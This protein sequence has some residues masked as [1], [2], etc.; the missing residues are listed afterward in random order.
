MIETER[1]ILRKFL[2]SDA[3]DMLKNWISDN[4][5]Q[6]RYGE[7]VFTEKRDVLEL[8][9]KWESQYRFAIILK[10]TGEN[11]GHVSFCR[12]YENANTAEIEY[13]VG[14]S[15]WNKGFTTEAIKAFIRH[16]FDNTSITKLEA[17]HK[18]ENPA[19][20]KVLQKSGMQAVDNVMRFPES[21]KAPDGD[22]CYAICRSEKCEFQE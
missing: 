21:E 4:D 12:L 18:I 10:E 22:I 11:I 5:V 17:F 14:K 13:C 7:P 15:F 9:K 3:D 8:L 16:T 19:S 20:G 6:S 1:L 2:L